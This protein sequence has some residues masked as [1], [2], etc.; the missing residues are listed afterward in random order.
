MCKHHRE[1]R[2]IGIVETVYTQQGRCGSTLYRRSSCPLNFTCGMQ[3]DEALQGVRILC[4][5]SFEGNSLKTGR[6]A[7]KCLQ[8]VMLLEPKTRQMFVDMD[9]PAKAAERLKVRIC[10]S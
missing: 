6:I 5:H 10:Y 4:R 9:F 3:V 8:N 1:E 2:D 7:L